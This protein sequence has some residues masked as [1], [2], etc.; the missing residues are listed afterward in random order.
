MSA[1]KFEQQ[2]H[3]REIV[4]P[5]WIEQRENADDTHAAW[6]VTALRKRDLGSDMNDFSPERLRRL[7]YLLV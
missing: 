6:S 7:T 3:C 1:V 2:A 5:S 4:T